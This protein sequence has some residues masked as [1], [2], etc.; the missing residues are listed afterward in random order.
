MKTILLPLLV[1]VL[2]CKTSQKNVQSPA[3]P[4]PRLPAFM[5]GNFTDDYNIRYTI[6]DSLWLQQPV[7]S[8]QV[9]RIDTLQQ[10]LIAK[11]GA[12]NP[13]D[14]NLYTRIDYMRFEN[15]APY[16]WGF[17]LTM[18]NAASDS[19]AAAAQPAD[20]QNPRKGCN[21]YPFS[22]MKRTVQ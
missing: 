5:T 9:L 17:C 1:L 4:A 2:A 16:H 22:R 11:N 13:S 14:Q 10:Y 12:H 6:T 20:R 19:L 18:Y 7:S 15:M 3:T 8:Y 21:S